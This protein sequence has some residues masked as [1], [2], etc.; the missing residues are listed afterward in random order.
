MYTH[1]FFSPL[2]FAGLETPPPSGF[3]LIPEVAGAENPLI[4]GA[5]GLLTDSP[6]RMTRS[7]SNVSFSS[8]IG[9]KGC[10]QALFVSPAVDPES[11]MSL[12]RMGRL[13]GDGQM[14]PVLI[15]LSNYVVSRLPDEVGSN[16][17][18]MTAAVTQMAAKTKIG[19]HSDEAWW[20]GLF[21]TVQL[22]GQA[23]TV[24]LSR[25]GNSQEHRLDPGSVYVLSGEARYAPWKHA[26]RNDGD[27]RVSVTFSYG[28]AADAAG[29]SV[30]QE[31]GGGKPFDQEEEL[32]KWKAWH[33]KTVDYT[34]GKGPSQLETV[35]GCGFFAGHLDHVAPPQGSSPDVLG[36]WN[37]IVKKACG[38][39]SPKLLSQAVE[40]GR[41][42][43]P[44]FFDGMGVGIV[45]T[46]E[47]KMVHKGDALCVW[48][49][50]AVL[51]DLPPLAVAS[52]MIPLSDAMGTSFAH[53][54]WPENVGV[55]INA[56][57]TEDEANCT[58]TAYRS[59]GRKEGV[60]HVYIIVSATKDIPYGVQLRWL[61]NK[62]YIRSIADFEGGAG[63]Y[64]REEQRAL[65][66]KHARGMRART[67]EQKKVWSVLVAGSP[68]AAAA[69]LP[70]CSAK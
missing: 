6:R 31:Q 23:T 49:G 4:S 50:L 32:A 48:G 39:V 64:S 36:T 9:D 38:V 52:C 44:G 2:I 58:Y 14:P 17:V 19:R 28:N 7:S 53:V 63:L 55:M 24:E 62:E 43:T 8:R 61:Y 25:D 35:G 12:R 57:F 20:G 51:G 15:E 68:V 34:L 47:S 42:Q 1:V 30:P 40:H 69:A 46:A 18:L 26:I 10:K 5:K 16:L 45:Q 56:A 66:D 54:P 27:M 3:F 22:Q 21:A 67:I 59:K 13:S 65:D 41:R 37:S 60:Y 33:Q 29:S 70:L 11:T